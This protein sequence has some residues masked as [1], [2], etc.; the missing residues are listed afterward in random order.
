MGKIIGIGFFGRVY[1]GSD[2]ATG[3]PVRAEEGG[4][5]RRHLEL[6][7]QRVHAQH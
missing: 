6:A 1:I 7:A 4:G 3:E 5:R 2:I